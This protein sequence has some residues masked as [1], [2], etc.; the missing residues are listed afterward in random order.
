MQQA[1]LRNTNEAQKGANKK[2]NDAADK[3]NKA[4][5]AEQKRMKPG[6]DQL[7]TASNKAVEAMKIS[8]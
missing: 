6:I 3:Y 8:E 1:E 7:D 5:A 2:Y 4:G